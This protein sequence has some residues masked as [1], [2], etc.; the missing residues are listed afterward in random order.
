VPG[1]IPESAASPAPTAGVEPETPSPEDGQTTGLLAGLVVL[2]LAL[3]SAGVWLARRDR[4]IAS[5]IAPAIPE[6]PAMSMPAADD[7]GPADDGGVPAADGPA[8]DEAG[9]DERLP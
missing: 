3:A 2:G 6:P 5:R 7:G 8:S 1:E 9:L 4:A